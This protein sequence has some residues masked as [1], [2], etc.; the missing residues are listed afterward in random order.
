MRHRNVFQLFANSVFHNADAIVR[1]DPKLIL[2]FT[3]DKKYEL[4][5]IATGGKTRYEY[6][7][8][9]KGD[10][11]YDM[12]QTDMYTRENE[13]K[14]SGHKYSVQEIKKYAEMFIDKII[15]C[16]DDHLNHPD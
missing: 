16:E 9:K 2:K 8:C 3:D 14:E 5:R 13:G 10:Y 6:S 4:D 1:A 15:E 7:F 11:T 12:N